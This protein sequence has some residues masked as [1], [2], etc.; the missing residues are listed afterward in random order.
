MKKIILTLVFILAF[1]C[2]SFGSSRNMIKESGSVKTAG[3]P[4]NA[5]LLIEPND[6]VTTGAYIEIQFENAIVFS[7]NVIDGK[8]LP[9]A[10][11]Y[12]SRGYQYIGYNNYKWDGKNGFYD[13]MADRPTSEVPYK[14]TRLSDYAVRVSLCN[15]PKAYVN[16]NISSFNNGTGIAHYA[17][18]LPVYVK[19]NGPV[20]VKL[21]GRVNDKGLTYG[22]YIFNESRT[23]VTTEATT[24]AENNNITSNK[25]DNSVNKVEVTVGRSIMVVNGESHIIDSQPY[26]QAGTGSILIPLRAVTIALTDGYTGKG[27]VNIVSWDADTKTAYI[28]YK[29]NKISFTAGSDIVVV[30]GQN[31]VIPNGAKAEISN[32]RMFVPFRALGEELDAQVNWDKDKKSAYFN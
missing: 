20:R 27:D 25:T 31:K 7:A 18:P 2:T 5:K 24:T 29:G 6:E 30:N 3:T 16:R 19:D 15:I 28:N 11:G 1:S 9:S 21:S 32:G 10:I 23:E 17:I 22:N 13:V 12:N 14:I 8:G 26:I 4:V